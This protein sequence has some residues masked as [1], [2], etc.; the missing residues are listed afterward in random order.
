MLIGHA[1]MLDPVILGERLQA[2]F[3]DLEIGSV[4]SAD[5]LE[6]ALAVGPVGLIIAGFAVDPVSGPTD[7]GWTCTDEADP[8]AFG[9]DAAGT[10]CSRQARLL[11]SWTP[12]IAARLVRFHN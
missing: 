7:T 9:L 8:S 4:D 10:F 1:P 11:E 5:G 3:P 12:S 2:R 6:R